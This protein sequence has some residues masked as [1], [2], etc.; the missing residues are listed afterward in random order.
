MSAKSLT[1]DERQLLLKAAR[2]TI[3]RAY[4]P[5]S[6][7]KVAA[8]ALT[9]KEKIYPGVN[10]ENE[11]YGLTVCAERA[12]IFNAVSHEGPKMRLVALAVVSD[13]EGSFPPCGACRQ[14]IAEFGPEAVIIFQGPEGLQ[15]IALAEL[16][17]AS[18]R[19]D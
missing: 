9:A 16:L 13:R 8:A 18:F 10:V 1:D 4:S 12:A 5:Y 11:S 19:L 14:V 17:P 3:P 2:M 6:G 7:I 15:E